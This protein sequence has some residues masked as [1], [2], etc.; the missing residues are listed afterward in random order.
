M[1]QE[2]NIWIVVQEVM[3]WAVQKE[4]NHLLSHWSELWV[5]ALM[6]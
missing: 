5:L 3:F 6:Q 4:C 1:L 2:E